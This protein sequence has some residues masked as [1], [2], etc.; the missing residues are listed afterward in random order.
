MVLPCGSKAQQNNRSC[1]SA[2]STLW[3]HW[4]CPARM[5]PRGLNACC[6]CKLFPADFV[7]ADVKTCNTCTSSV[8][9]AWPFFEI[10]RP[11]VCLT[12][13]TFAF[14]L[15]LPG[16]TTCLACSSDGKFLSVGHSQGFSVW[17]VSSLDCVSEW[18]QDTVEIT[19][20]QFVT[21]TETAHLLCTIDDMGESATTL[22]WAVSFA[23][24]AD[25]RAYFFL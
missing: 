17:C 14:F 6:T 4:R 7:W 19:A 15:K 20:I 2:C 23:H 21:L 10:W 13:I 16:S 25:A 18:L 22:H 3:W 24:F 12:F 1:I 8:R 9:W 11:V 5:R